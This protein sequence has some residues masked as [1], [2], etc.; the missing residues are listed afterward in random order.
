MLPTRYEQ[1]CKACHWLTF[2][3]DLPKV[4]VPH[5]LQPPDVN[6]FL[7]GAFAQSERKKQPPRDQAWS[8]PLPGHKL[9]REEEARER[10]KS[11]VVRAEDYLRQDDL[12]KAEKYVHEARA[13]CGLCHHYGD[14][15]LR[16]LATEV[17]PVWYEHAQ[18]SHLAHRTVKCRECHKDADAAGLDYPR[19]LLPDVENCR[20]CHGPAVT[21]SRNSQGGVRFV[22]VTC[23]RY[24]NG[25]APLAGLGADARGIKD[26]ER[27]S[28][29][30]YLRAP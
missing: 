21:A 30:D 11:N 16:V 17:P 19:T 1:H 14:D 2:S 25:D 10:I 9:S 15:K 24:H 27:R 29:Q 6:R 20:K 12:R 7:W 28:I 13:T 5:G 8:L 18:F 22:C 23:H 3:D 4:E 26:E